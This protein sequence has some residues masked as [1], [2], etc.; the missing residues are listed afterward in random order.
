MENFVLIITICVGMF[1]SHTKLFCN[2]DTTMASQ[3]ENPD[4]SE[5]GAPAPC[6]SQPEKEHS[7]ANHVLETTRN[8][9]VNIDI[10][11]G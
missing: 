5:E 2:R 11:R 4:R 1:C 6:T 10:Q 9:I 8:F 3:G 7:E